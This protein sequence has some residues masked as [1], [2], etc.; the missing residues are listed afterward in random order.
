MV[1]SPELLEEVFSFRYK[2]A[3]EELNRISANKRKQDID[4]YDRYSI[5]F[6]AFDNRGKICATTR[7]IVNSPIGYPTE[8]N[9][10]FELNAKKK[11]RDK[12]SEI[13]RI[14]ISKEVRGIKNTKIIIDNF[15]ELIYA[16]IKLYQVEYIYGALEITFLR[17]LQILKINYQVIGEGAEYSGFRYPCLLMVEDLVQDN[18]RLLKL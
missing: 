17:L 6:A 9:L 5:H 4:V 2:V 18:T 8:N 15:I 16:Y 13:S 12:F 11:E 7:F 3:Y 14:F 10:Q 1:D